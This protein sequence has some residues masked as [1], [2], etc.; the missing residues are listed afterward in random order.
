MFISMNTVKIIDY[1]II[2]LI[3]LTDRMNRKC[4]RGKTK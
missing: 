4:K 1:Q 2:Y 3:K